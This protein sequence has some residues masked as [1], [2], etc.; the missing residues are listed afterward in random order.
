M[1][2]SRTI[3]RLQEPRLATGASDEEEKYAHFHAVTCWR[4]DED[5]RPSTGAGH[6]SDRRAAFRFSGVSKVPIS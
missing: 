4:E 1:R 3:L 6:S 5:E 2:Q